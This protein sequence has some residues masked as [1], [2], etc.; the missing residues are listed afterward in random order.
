MNPRNLLVALFALAALAYGGTKAYLYFKIKNAWNSIAETAAP[1]AELKR[2]GIT[3]SL[4]GAAGVTDVEIILNDTS[5]SIRID[6][7]EVLVPN[8]RYLLK[9]DRAADGVR[10]GPMMVNGTSRT[11]PDLPR[12]I[13]VNV[14]GVHIDLNSAY[15]MDLDRHSREAAAQNGALETGCGDIT[16]FG[17]TQYREM[18]YDTIKMD[19]KLLFYPDLA[20]RSFSF[21]LDTGVAQMFRLETDADFAMPEAQG[22]AAPTPRLANLKL[23][24]KDESLQK[25]IGDLCR[26][27]GTP[28]VKTFREG[29]VTAFQT[30]MRA[31]GIELTPEMIATYMKFLERPGSLTIT[32]GPASPVDLAALKLYKAADVPALLNLDMTTSP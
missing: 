24:Y 18:G 7:I 4:T 20:N 28:D 31:M 19:M 14:S 13:G 23:V 10:G 16:H 3:S 15:M 26:K 29:Q 11:V 9:A 1:Y 6:R 12:F 21:K 25:R 17:T 8:I 32:S 22:Y 5:E 30:Q 2:G 27:H